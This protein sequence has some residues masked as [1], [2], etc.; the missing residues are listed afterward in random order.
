M[1]TCDM[2]RASLSLWGSPEPAEMPRHTLQTDLGAHK[3]NLALQPLPSFLGEHR[4]QM[5]QR[6]RKDV[7]KNT[8]APS[9][10]L[11]LLSPYP[12][13]PSWCWDYSK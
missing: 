2:S 4:G 1:A 5:V 8:T 10:Y 9:F 3:A 13:F 12:P 7:R 6:K 11:P